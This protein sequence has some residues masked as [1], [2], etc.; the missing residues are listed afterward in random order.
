VP[1]LRGLMVGLRYELPLELWYDAAL[2]G[3]GII[4]FCPRAAL[5]VTLCIY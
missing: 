3:L 2:R 4:E 1:G 5:G